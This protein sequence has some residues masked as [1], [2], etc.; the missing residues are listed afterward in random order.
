MHDGIE[1]R[2]ETLILRVLFAPE[3]AAP[4]CRVDI[5]D[6]IDVVKLCRSNHNVVQVHCKLL[7]RGGYLN[8]MHE[9]RKGMPQIR[10][11]WPIPR[12]TH[13]APCGATLCFAYVAE[14]SFLPVKDVA[15]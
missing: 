8:D 13:C 6:C 3:P 4:Q 11:R 1:T 14:M 10:H 9:L 5:G 7:D 12:Q 2:N 15:L